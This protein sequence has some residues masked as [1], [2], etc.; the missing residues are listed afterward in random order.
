MKLFNTFSNSYS[1]EIVAFFHGTC[2][3]RCG[4]SPKGGKKIGSR[5]LLQAPALRTRHGSGAS[6]QGG[7][8]SRRLMGGRAPG[9]RG[10]AREQAAAGARLPPVPRAAH[11]RGRPA[12]KTWEEGVSC[13]GTV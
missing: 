13:G 11:F 6:R 7:W 2:F 5:S 10:G 9:G 1:F 3:R 4:K 12:G 8:L